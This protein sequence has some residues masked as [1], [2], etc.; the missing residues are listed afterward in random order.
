MRRREWLKERAICGVRLQLQESS[1]PVAPLPVASGN[2]GTS[3]AATTADATAAVARRPPPSRLPHPRPSP[4]RDCSMPQAQQQQEWDDAVQQVQA[5]A[6]AGDVHTLE[7]LLVADAHLLDAAGPD[8]RTALHCAVV[9]GQLGAAECLLLAGAD[10]HG[11]LHLAAAAAHAAAPRLV[12]LLLN[13][14][15]DAAATDSSSRTPLH[16][17]AASTGCIEVLVCLA[18]HIPRLLAARAGAGG[19]TP[20]HALCRCLAQDGS[21]SLRL[22]QALAAERLLGGPCLEVPDAAGRTALSLAAAAGSLEAVRLLLACGGSPCGGPCQACRSTRAAGPPMAGGQEQEQGGAAWGSQEAAQRSM[23]GHTCPLAAACCHT[24]CSILLCLLGAGA[25]AS[26]LSDLVLARAVVD[27]RTDVAAA[28]LAA[29]LRSDARPLLAA[30]QR[31]VV[32]MAGPLEEGLVRA[33]MEGGEPGPVH[34]PGG[35]LPLPPGPTLG[36]QAGSVCRLASSALP[37]GPTARLR[38]PTILA[39]LDPNSPGHPAAARRLL[40]AALLPG[41]ERLLQQLLLPGPAA[42]AAAGRASAPQQAQQAQQQPRAAVGL[43]V[44]TLAHQLQFSPANFAV[45]HSS[46]AALQLLLAAGCPA[47]PV[48]APTG[49]PPLVIAAG[50]LDIAR[51]RALLEAGADA[52]ESWWCCRSVSMRAQPQGSRRWGFA[53]GL[54]QSRGHPRHWRRLAPGVQAPPTFAGGRHWMRCWSRAP[55]PA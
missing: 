19:D 4:F 12:R 49:C 50:R 10:A 15:A 26:G 53:S 46:L 30:V 51:C 27:V 18:R 54:W 7:Q 1:E 42:P 16:A 40:E 22:L 31:S 34:A 14:G 25:S 13:Q 37:S 35:C 21:T 17:A 44:G 32:G 38:P 43:D 28:L 47:G 55:M 33:L 23:Q 6:A 20:L 2:I 52:G 39:G 24:S 11:A 8:G 41:R 9:H 29:G 48:P 5:A 36:D 3:S 45:S